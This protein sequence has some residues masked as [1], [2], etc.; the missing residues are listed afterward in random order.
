MT[1]REECSITLL[2]YV[3]HSLDGYFVIFVIQCNHDYMNIDPDSSYFSVLS[4]E[5]SRMLDLVRSQRSRV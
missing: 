2:S 1:A 4:H 3:P 5:G